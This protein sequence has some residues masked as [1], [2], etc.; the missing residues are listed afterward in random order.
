MDEIYGKTGIT[1][2]F[3]YVIMVIDYIISF[4][5]R[6]RKCE[7]AEDSKYAGYDIDVI[8]T[9]FKVFQVSA[10]SFPV[11]LFLIS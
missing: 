1:F 4:F 9:S 8:V 6:N 5:N 2:L 10:S 3:F 11:F 7:A